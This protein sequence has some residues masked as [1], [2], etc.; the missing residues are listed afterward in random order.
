M[1]FEGRYVFTASMD[2][3]SEKEAL[4]NEIYDTEHVPLLSAV[5]GVVSVA[6][7]KTQRELVLAIGGELRTIVVEESEPRYSAL[8]E[9][10]SPD[11]IHSEAWSEASE[12]GRWA[13]EVS[14]YT[15]NRRHTLR[16]LIVPGEQA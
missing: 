8:Y 4:F 9:V 2:V 13:D 5:P 16:K 11:V 3:S 12:Q 7:F 14:P 1:P 10:E 15:K 6:R